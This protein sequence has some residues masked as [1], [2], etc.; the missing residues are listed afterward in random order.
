MLLYPRKVIKDAD[1][2]VLESTYGDRVHSEEDI[3]REL[4]DVILETHKNRG[5]LMIPTFAVERTQELMFLLNDL[6]VTESIPKIPI[7]LDSP[8]GINSTNVYD[9]YPDLHNHSRY[10]INQMYDIA[11]LLSSFLSLMNAQPRNNHC[12]FRSLFPK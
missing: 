7:Y 8:M 10:V 9:K 1:V 12:F 3:K 5:I 2:L 4:R 6:I 11:Q